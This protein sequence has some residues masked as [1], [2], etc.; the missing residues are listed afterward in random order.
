MSRNNHD[1]NARH[2]AAAVISRELQ[3][4]QSRRRWGTWPRM[5]W[6]RT[7]IPEIVIITPRRFA[8]ARGFFSETFSQRSYAAIIPD[9]A[10]VQDNLSLSGP[11]F[12][13]RGLHFQAPPHAQA[14]LVSVLKGAVLDVAV[15]IRRGSPSFGRHVAVTLT[16]ERGEQMFVPAGFAHG[17]CTLEPDTM[18]AYKASDFYA[19]EADRGLFWADPALAIAWPMAEGEAALSERDRRHPPLAAFATPFVYAPGPT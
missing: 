3:R 2:D 15:D 10:F 5:E 4:L 14:K 12:T 19:P 7:A 9:V 11:R 8:D 16:A 18:V 13:V 6:T 17:F 1:A